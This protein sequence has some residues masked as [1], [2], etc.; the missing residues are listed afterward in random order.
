MAKTLA[1]VIAVSV[2]AL[3]FAGCGGGGST[4]KPV[5][6]E[7][8]RVLAGPDIVALNSILKPPATIK[9]YVFMVRLRYDAVA[10][11]WPRTIIAANVDSG[12]TAAVA[13]WA[14][15]YPSNP[16]P[17]QG[18]NT[19][20]QQ[21]SVESATPIRK[22]ELAYLDEIATLWE[23]YQVEACVRNQKSD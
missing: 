11:S 22:D 5:A 17:F 4:S 20:A 19:R 16:S 18:L 7:C 14:M 23:V 8:E 2:A 3:L 10:K 13:I 6:I 12:G 15:G 1:G 21:V 9:G